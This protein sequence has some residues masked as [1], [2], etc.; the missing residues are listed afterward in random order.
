RRPRGEDRVELAADLL[1]CLQA[2]VAPVELGDVAELAAVRAA[3][4]E[5]DAREEVLLDV[6]QAVGGSRE[7]REGRAVGSREAKL[8]LRALAALREPRVEG[9]GRVAQLSQVQDVEFRI[10]GRRGGD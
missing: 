1:G 9:T 10:P 2:R 5:L 7:V 3:R 8:L 6:D 4:G